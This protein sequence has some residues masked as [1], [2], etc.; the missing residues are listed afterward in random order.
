M[1]KRRAIVAFP[2]GVA[3]LYAVCTFL[4]P[5]DLNFVDCPELRGFTFNSIVFYVLSGIS[6]LAL[7]LWVYSARAGAK[8]FLYLLMPLAVGFS[9]YY[10]NQELRQRLVPDVFDKAGSITKQFLPNEELSRLVIVGSELSGLYRSLFYLDNPTASLET[11]P[12]GGGYDLAKVPAGKEWVLEAVAEHDGLL[13]KWE[14]TFV[15]PLLLM[16]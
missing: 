13:T 15:L 16:N 11:I 9:T 5:Y 10:V 6:F 4:A 3:I 8:I 12:E 1:L 7:A 2:I 14:L